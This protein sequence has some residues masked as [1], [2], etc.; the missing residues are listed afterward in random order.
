MVTL[1]MRGDQDMTSDVSAAAADVNSEYSY[2]IRLGCY[3]G[4]TA[5]TDLASLINGT[6]PPT[7]RICLGFSSNCLNLG[8]VIE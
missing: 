3:W 4:L 6:T 2:I 8:N 7:K 1:K 5:K